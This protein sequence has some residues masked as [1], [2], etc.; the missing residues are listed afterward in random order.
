MKKTTWFVGAMLILM[1]ASSAAA[2][3]VAGLPLHVKRLN[4]NTI[5][6][7]VGDYSSSTAIVAFSTSKGIVVVDTTGNP[8]VDALLRKVIAR[9]LGRSDFKL[10]INTHE[11]SDHTGGNSVYADC[12]IVGHE[13]VAA[14]MA[15]TAPRKQEM[16]DWYTK[17]I[18]ENEQK[19]TKLQADS[20]EARKLGERLISDRLNLEAVRSEAKP[21]P[22]TKTL[23]DHLKLD[24]GDT[25]F[26]LYYIGGMHSASDIAVFVP[27]HGIL[28]TGDT[29]ADTWLNETPGCLASF[30]A[31]DGVRH[32]F[33]LLLAN[34]HRILAQKGRIKILIP[35]HWNGEL[36]LAGAEARV[37]YVRTLWEGVGKAAKEGTSL[38]EVQAAFDLSKRFPELAESPGCNVRNHSS[39]I[40]EIWKIT[41]NQESAATKLYAL[42]DENAS[43]TAVR[44][45]IDERD[46]ATPKYYFVEGEIN[47]RGYQLLQDNKVDKAIALFK[48]NVKLFPEAWNVYDSLGEALL[49]S[50]DTAGATKMYKKSLA[51]NPKSTSGKDALAKISAAKA[52]T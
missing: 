33:P 36:S 35:G 20:P 30:A 32:D 14:G 12:T 8:K 40:M 41:T 22:P 51:L 21:A 17:S 9:E 31:R 16:I 43:E 47:A 6:L 49:K 11:H 5:R 48:L 27:E 19:L 24:M 10:L 39:T 2:E 7:W 4:P 23:S 38:P 28:L 18:D 42:I 44:D 45:V 3:Q 46:K 29:M 50:G 1:F 34:W 15:S 37:N 52:T 25:T 26:D 13:L